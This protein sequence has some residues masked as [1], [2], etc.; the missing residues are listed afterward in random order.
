[1]TAAGCNSSGSN[2]QTPDASTGGDDAG[3]EGGDELLAPPPI[4]RSQTEAQLAP[5]RQS[6]AFGPGSWP[7][8][9]IG[10]D[11]PVGP[12]IPIDHVIVIMQEN[13]SFDH[14]LGRLVAQGYYKA[15]DF[16]SPT[17]EGFSHPDELDAPPAGWSN[18]DSNGTVITP[19]ADNEHCYGVNHSWG[20][21]HDD[22]DNG[23]NDHFVTQNDPDGQRTFFYEDDTVIP[24][25]YALASTFGVGDRYFCSVLSS[26]WPNRFFLMAATSFGIG[27]NSFNTL[28]TPDHPVAQIFSELEAGGH[29][30]KD[31]TDGPHMT[32]F[33]PYFGIQKGVLPH[34][35]TVKCDLLNDITSDT[36]PDVSFVMGDEVD[37]DSDEGPSDLPGIGGQVVE[38]IIRT[39]FASPAW[40]HTAVFITYDENGGIADHVVPGPACPPDDLATPHDGNG[41]TLTPGTFDTTGFRVPFIVVSPYTKAHYVSHLVHD[42]ASITR[43]IETRFGLPAMTGRD[44]NALPPLEMFDFKNPPFLTPPSIAA[45]TPVDPTVLASCKQSLAPL[46]CSQ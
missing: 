21:Q 30:W 32:A 13:R 38:T 24:F 44:A 22:Y 8:Q 20:A 26:T 15:G 31:Y 23:K 42:H 41:T 16:S 11:Y 14:Y 37:E 18:T 3:L 2:A 34:L 39:L 6:C 7:A 46:S 27:D 35:G 10:T 9:T 12:D 45:H 17:A 4:T 28:D 36:L 43:F 1:L 33:F 40:K 29:T 5:Q 19:H 25:Y